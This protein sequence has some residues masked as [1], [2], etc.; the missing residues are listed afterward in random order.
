VNRHKWS[1]SVSESEVQEFIDKNV[2]ISEF[3]NKF[4]SEVTHTERAIGLARFFKWLRV[5]KGLEMS[6]SE[7]LDLHLK[8]RVYDSVEDRRWALK[9][10]LEF[11][12]I[13][14]T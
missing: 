5:V 10:V 9:L 8:K 1:Y 3:L 2:A 13:I 11:A 6:P 4:D 7:F 14:L 12:G